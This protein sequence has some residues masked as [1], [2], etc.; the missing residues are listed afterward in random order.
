MRD[1][2]FRS[3]AK[4]VAMVQRR[5]ISSEELLQLYLDRVRRF[6][7]DLN[8]IVVMDVKRARTRAREADAAIARGESWGKLHGLPMTIKESYNV[9][10]LPTTFG[11]PAF[12]NNIAARDALAVQRLKRAGVVLFGKTNVPLGLADFQSYN[13]IYGTTN[14][15]WNKTRIPGGSS[16]G[17]AAALAAG[18]TGF[19]SGSDIGGSIRNPAH[20]CGVFGHKPTWGLLPTRGHTLGTIAPSDLSV[21]GP[22][23][24]SAED[25]ELGVSVMAGPDEIQSMG[26]RSRYLSAVKNSL[27]DYRARIWENDEQAPLC[28]RVVGVGP[29]GPSCYVSY[30][31]G[32]WW[33]HRLH[34]FCQTIPPRRV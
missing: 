26:S 20:F 15:P 1:I 13:A 10:G 17:S 8:A 9:A 16:G 24:R 7:P 25:L 12:K 27:R 33:C 18:M 32:Y 4:L 21:I 23:G 22:M 30:S 11:N 28:Q 31:T 2:A 6:N 29:A 3:A 14:N 34:S 19:E 5:E